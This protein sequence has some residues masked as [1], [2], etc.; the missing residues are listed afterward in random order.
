MSISL[1]QVFEKCKSEKRAALIGYITAGF[2]T[3][4]KSKEIAMAMVDKAHARVGQTV[5]AQLRGQSIA[6]DV[7]QLPYMINFNIMEVQ[8]VVY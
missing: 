4:D 3:L 5:W 7:H 8:L 1:G 2:P 6:M